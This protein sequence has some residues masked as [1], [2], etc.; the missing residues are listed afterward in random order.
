MQNYQTTSDAD[1]RISLFGTLRV[2]QGHNSCPISSS[3]VKNLLAYLLLYP[4]RI[5]TREYLADLLWPDTPPERVR[6]NLSDTLYRLRQAVGEGLLTIDREKV[7]LNKEIKLWV[8]VWE[9]KRLIDSQDPDQLIQA[10]NL[11]RDD[12]LPELYDD[13]IL[14]ERVG[15]REKYLD[16]LE[17]RVEIEQAKNNLPQALTYARR[18][19][20]AE[21]LRE[22]NQRTYILLLGRLNHR[23]EAIVHYEYLEKLLQQELGLEPMPETKAAIQAIR[24]EMSLAAPTSLSTEL[25][26]FVG[27]TQERTILLE[28]VEAAIGGQGGLLA[29]EGP[30]GIG[31]SRLLR[32]VAAG[33]RWRGA[34]VITGRAS[35]QPMASPLAPLAKALAPALAGPRAAL[36]EAILPPTSLARLAPLY[37]QWQELADLPE[38]PPQQA[39]SLFHQA[40]KELIMAL[41]TF[42]PHIVILDDLHWANPALW[43]TLDALLPILES[44]AVLFLL[45]YRR[46]E[47]EQVDGWQMLQEW[48]RTARLSTLHL[49]PL[50]KEEIVEMLPPQLQPQAN[51]VAASTGGN[52]FFIT[53]LL[54]TRAQDQLPHGNTILA[55]MEGLTRAARAA[56]EVAAVI[57][58]EVPFRLWT[59][60]ADLPPDFL[61]EASEQLEANYFLQPTKS[62]YGFSHDLVHTTIY[63]RIDPV[64]RQALHRQ[65]ADHLAN[66]DPDNWPRRAFHLDRAGAAAEAAAMYR[67][68]GEQDQARF[69]FQ[70]AQAAFD[71]ALVLISSRPSPE[72]VEILLALARVCQVTG[73]RNRLEAALEEAL[74]NAQA[75]GHQPLTTETLLLSGS[76][77]AQTGQIETATTFLTQAH[78]LAKQGSD[79][80][81]QI[82]ALFLLGDLAARC[83]NFDEARDYFQTAFEKAQTIGNRQ[84]EAKALRGIGIAARQVGQIEQ[85]L[86][87]LEKALVVQKQINDR[88]GAS[89]TQANLLGGYYYRGAWDR[90]LALA[91]EAL[92]IKEA[93]GDRLGG[94]I[95]RQQQGLAAYALGDFERARSLLEEA[96]QVCDAVGEQRTA[97]LTQNVLGLVAEAEENL[98]EARHFY[99]VALDIA[100]AAGATTEAAYAQHDLGALYVQLN[101]PARALPLLEAARTTWTKQNNDLLRLKSEAYLALAHLAL[102]QRDRAEALAQTGWLAF[103][104]GIPQGEQPQAWLWTLHNLLN[105]LTRRQEAGQVLQTAYKELQRQAG[106]ITQV[107]M[108]HSFFERVPLNRTIVAAYDRL[109]RRLRQITVTLARQ[110]A[111]LGRTLTPAEMVS[112]SWTVNAPEDEGIANKSERRRYRLQR[113]LAEAARQGAAPTD[114]DLAGALGVS[115]RTIL[116]DMEVLTQAGLAV[117]TRRRARQ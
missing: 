50:V 71:R 11:Y 44:Q 25:T 49:S 98:A 88:L 42:K 112:I 85:A 89:I 2:E 94:A 59:A 87:W 24:R 13:W 83:G 17:T 45:A 72:R 73:H 78:A 55:R 5:H 37:A 91:D 1:Y 108:R 95:V 109:T 19:I 14:P 97:G 16:G 48:E 62:G 114:G 30:A 74:Q 82:E 22:H 77:A 29:V 103:Q 64:R 7:Q 26:P 31:K 106:A 61:A 6:R 28:A 36:M 67:R 66:L 43:A 99:E 58:T 12:L 18:L 15:L 33:A 38:L 69:A 34:V 75:L 70:E 32:E 116:R 56:L 54:I 115:R 79:E 39:Q 110:D 52:P 46:P 96:L 20:R 68:V 51:V 93:L 102:D 107:E 3:N 65:A 35:A 41:A 4:D 27:R 90:L 101:D 53:E 111:P 105:N 104:Q 9:F 113:L 23:N 10:V 47:I 76:I 21:P 80:T 63:N 84:Q 81:Q 117:S 86:E 60:L 40:L 92:A 8:D 57:G 100:T